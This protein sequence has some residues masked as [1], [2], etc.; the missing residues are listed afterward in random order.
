MSVEMDG[1]VVGND[2]GSDGEVAGVVVKGVVAEGEE[3][4]DGEEVEVIFVD[5][6]EEK[7]G[8]EVTFS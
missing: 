1:V 5:C 6:V 4:E 3:E 2:V 7:N 8:V